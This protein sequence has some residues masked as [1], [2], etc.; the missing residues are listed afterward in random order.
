M[1]WQVPASASGNRVVGEA[2]IDA[3]DE[4]ARVARL[5][6][7]LDRRDEL[8]GEGLPRVLEEDGAA[9]DDVDACGED[10]C[11]SPPARRA[12][13]C[14][15]SRCRR[16]TRGSSP[17]RSSRSVVAV[18]PVESSSPASSAAS[19]PA[20]ESRDTHTPV[21]SNRGSVMS[22]VSACRPT[23][24]VPIASDLECH[25]LAPH[26]SGMGRSRFGKVMPPSTSSVL[27]VR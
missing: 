3:V 6:G 22:W 10:A 17:A 20:L 23:L 16:R 11:G 12:G 2:G 5:G 15:P 27:P 13:G 14:R 4:Q 26:R 24:P 1:L 25:E 18:M 7:V 8:L 9:A 19:L 21:S